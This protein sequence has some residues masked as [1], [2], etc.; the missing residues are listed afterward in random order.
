VLELLRCDEMQGY[1]I[2][3]PCPRDQIAALL[4]R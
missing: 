1:L 2:G 3:R 4:R